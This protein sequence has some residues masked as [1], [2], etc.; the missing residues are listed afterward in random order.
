MTEI[1]VTELFIHAAI[2]DS[3]LPDIGRPARLKAQALPYFHTQ[4]E[5][6]DW[7]PADYVHGEPIRGK[8]VH[9]RLRL[10]RIA[11]D[12][13][14]LDDGG[15]PEM[16]RER[17]W[18]G[19]S[20]RLQAEDISIWERANELIRLVSRERNR[21]CLWAYA[22]AQAKVLKVATGEHKHKRLSFSKW[23]ATIEDIHRNYGKVCA[24]TAIA[25]ISGKLASKGLQP[26]EKARNCTLRLT[27]EISDIRDK[28]EA[29]ASRDY[30][31]FTTDGWVVKDR[32]RALQRFD[33]KLIYVDMA[34]LRN[35]RRRKQYSNKAKAA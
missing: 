17:F 15:R 9:E 18:A 31:T 29:S 19:L 3:R 32:E 23:C 5:K 27:P 12:K 28:M 11:D 7:I 34:D 8:S 6:K 16:E 24:G 2:V 21:R 13:L 22:M 4:A 26:N 1:Q 35:R 25:E 30:N 33:E 14:E 20:T 10:K